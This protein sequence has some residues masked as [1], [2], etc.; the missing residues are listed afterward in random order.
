MRAI[1]VKEIQ[2]HFQCVCGYN[3]VDSDRVNNL[4]WKDISK[5]GLIK[6]KDKKTGLFMNIH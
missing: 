2:T 6:R 5:A 3:E 4:R 1:T